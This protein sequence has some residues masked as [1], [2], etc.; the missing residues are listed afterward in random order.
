[1]KK[2]LT[3]FFALTLIVISCTSTDRSD[4]SPVLATVQNSSLTLNEAL[5]QIPASVLEQDTASAV[6]SYTEQWVNERV[7]IKEAE[8]IGLSNSPE[9]REKLNRLRGQL[10]QESLKDYVLNE[11]KDEIEVTRQEA[12][13]Y[14]QAHKEKF[15]LEERYV[16]FRHLTTRTR[17]EADNAKRDL[18]RGIPWEEVANTYSVNSEFQLRK[19]NQFWPISMSVSDNSLLNQYLNVIGITEISPIQ[20]FGGQYHFVQLLEERPEGD[21]P[22]LEWLIPQIV[23]WLKLE[24]AR[25]ITN[26]Y[27]RNLYLESE[28][29]NEINQAGATEIN[30]FITNLSN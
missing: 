6:R 7:M 28:A 22:D 15:T 14:Y 16:R 3:I 2:S 4:D 26:G 20:Y 19:S 25:R 9:I 1:M 30:R 11:H 5:R 17:T 10:L 18:M 13:N 12:Q 8:R 27:V 23:E 24:K 29:N 21:H